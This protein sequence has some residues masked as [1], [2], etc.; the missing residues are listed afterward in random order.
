[1]NLTDT[2]SS[3]SD[4]LC[5]DEK[6]KYY[7]Y[8]LCERNGDQ[9][10]PFYIGKGVGERMWNHKET[11]E[12][13]LEEYI[14]KYKSDY[15]KEYGEEASAEALDGIS[16][17][18]SE[19]FA[20]ENQLKIAK[21]EELKNE[22]RLEHVIVKWGLTENEAFMAES[23]LINMLD[24][25][26]FGLTNKVGGH[27]SIPEKSVCQHSQAMTDREFCE[28]YAKEML[29][30][31]KMDDCVFVSIGRL[32]S[33]Y[34]DSKS[35][36]YLSQVCDT[37]RACWHFDSKKHSHKFLIAVFNKRICGVYK[38]TEVHSI[39]DVKDDSVISKYPTFPEAV[40]AKEIA[41][42][43]YIKEHQHLRKTNPEQFVQECA[44]ILG[45]TEAKA[46]TWLN[47]KFFVCEDVDPTI[48]DD[49]KGRRIG[50]KFDEEGQPKDSVF[51]PRSS[52]ICPPYSK[53]T[54][55]K[56]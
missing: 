3:I 47:R 22:N 34:C 20:N 27:A 14:E 43:K 42:L 51:L 12:S 23:T 4:T 24:L 5:K 21:I 10:A 41:A 45:E 49:R 29:D 44:E 31:K 40:R 15:K 36:D 6:R 9:L 1:M 38:I 7:V 25:M 37:A 52:G 19:S 2:R 33:L 11:A 48:L 50:N 46:K 54:D 32:H 55:K 26:D 8:A 17:R 56:K 53:H 28:K 13:A 35:K 18:F 30:Y 16:A 39:K